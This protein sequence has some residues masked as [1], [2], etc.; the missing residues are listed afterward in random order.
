[1][2]TF[3]LLGLIGFSAGCIS[4]SGTS[5][6][7]YLSGKVKPTSTTRDIKFNL[8]RL[9]GSEGH[10]MATAYP[11]TEPLILKMADEASEKN[12]DS[13]TAKSKRLDDLMKKFKN[14][15]NCFNFEVKASDI[16]HAKMSLYRAVVEQES[17]KLDIAYFEKDHKPYLDSAHESN[18]NAAITT[19]IVGRGPHLKEP[20]PH[21]T[22]DYGC[23]SQPV[24]FAK[25]FKVYLI[26]QFDN[27]NAKRIEFSW[28]GGRKPY[29]S[30]D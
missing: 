3:F 18:M 28:D 27:S 21:K 11:I 9:N 19:A 8:I 29:Q 26:P 24:N 15:N 20:Y 7:D 17:L 2:K 10:Y 14:G 23:T 5:R 22:S 16:R 30:Q 4:T 1:M 13:D 12:F 6:E 25:P